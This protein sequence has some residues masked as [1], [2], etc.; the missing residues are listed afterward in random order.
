M[1]TKAEKLKSS[2]YVVGRIRVQ[3]QINDKVQAKT[4]IPFSGSPSPRFSILTE[5]FRS[6]IFYY[7]PNKFLCLLDFGFRAGLLVF[8]R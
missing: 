3:V 4:S 5:H 2:S 7:Y 8:E 6:C 1:K